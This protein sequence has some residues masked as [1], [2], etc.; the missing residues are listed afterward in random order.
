MTID[1]G[2]SIP[3]KKEQSDK[4]LKKMNKEDKIKSIGKSLKE[5]SF[6]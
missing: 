1:N 4:A 6:S 2:F 3:N 5:I